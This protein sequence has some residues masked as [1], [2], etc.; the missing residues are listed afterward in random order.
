MVSKLNKKI[1]KEIKFVPYF[2]APPVPP[3]HFENLPTVGTKLEG[4]L[5][6]E[7]DQ[8]EDDDDFDPRS[9]ENNSNS[10]PITT[11]NGTTNSPPLCRF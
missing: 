4:L 3:R 8:V 2:L 9:Y 10:S 6:N 11:T 5:L 1:A 7:F